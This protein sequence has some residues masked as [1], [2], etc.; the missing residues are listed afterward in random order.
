MH[1]YC[2]RVT[3]LLECFKWALNEPHN[4]TMDMASTMLS[5]PSGWGSNFGAISFYYDL[6]FKGHVT[7][8]LDHYIGIEKGCGH[9]ASSYSYIQG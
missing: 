6:I 8:T 9:C 7:L 2:I 4:R 3:A 1:N 5:V